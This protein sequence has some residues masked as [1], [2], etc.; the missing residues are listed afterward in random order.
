MRKMFLVL[1]CIVAFTLVLAGCAGTSALKEELAQKEAEIQDLKEEAAALE[2]RV[3]ELQ[4]EVAAL[5]QSSGSVLPTALQVM[6]LIK[7]R[8][9]AALAER[10]HPEKG[11]RFSPYT[12]VEPEKDL[13]FSASELPE[14]LKSDRVYTWG[15]YDGSGNPIELTFSDYYDRFV[16]DQDFANPHVIGNNVVVSSG[17]TINNIN[18]AYP[19]GRF[20]EFHFTGIDPRYEGMDWRSLSLV[21]K[22]NNNAWQLVGIVHNE[23]TI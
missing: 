20:V 19:D 23:W 3:A 14:L 15:A 1:S 12:F 13:R 8:D 7:K 4:E 10:V 16:Y 11:V 21:F 18:E 2:S 6:E 5:R 17:N 9:M 22:K